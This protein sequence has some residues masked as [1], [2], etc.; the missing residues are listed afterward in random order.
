MTCRIALAYSSGVEATRKCSG[1]DASTPPAAIRLVTTGT[2]IAI[3]S[4]ILFCVPRAM[5]S[6][7]TISAERRRYGRTSGTDPVT[8]T[9]G[10][11]PSRC[12]AGDGSAP[13]IRSLRL[14]RRALRSGSV[15]AQKSNM[16]SWF[17]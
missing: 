15:L 16:H 13:T 6:G 4:R 8:V 14:G 3:A 17:G 12:T 9:P 10:S 11:F 5:F 7:A 1:P 2:P